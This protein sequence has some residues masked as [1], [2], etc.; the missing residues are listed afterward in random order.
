MVQCFTI[1]AAA[2]IVARKNASGMQQPSDR[3]SMRCRPERESGKPILR[4]NLPLAAETPVARRHENDRPNLR[5]RRGI[6][7]HSILRRFARGFSAL[8]KIIELAIQHASDS[9]E[10]IDRQPR[11]F[12]V[13]DSP[14]V[15]TRI[16]ASGGGS[17]FQRQAGSLSKTFDFRKIDAHGWS[18]IKYGGCVHCD[19]LTAEMVNGNRSVDTM[20]RTVYSRLKAESV[21]LQTE[22]ARPDRSPKSP[23][24][25]NWR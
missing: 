12:P 23:G 6:A 21:R 17:I 2:M 11:L 5:R 8:N 7:P 20:I 3:P 19:R 4:E 16:E 15:L 9:G 10:R 24:R 18:V 13:L 22:S 14:P 1:A 25:A